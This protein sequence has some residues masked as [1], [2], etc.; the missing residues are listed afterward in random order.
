MK[1][2]ASRRGFTLIEMMIVIAIIGVL[3]G[4]LMAGISSIRRSAMRMQANEVITALY[5]AVDVYRLEHNRY[6]PAEANHQITVHYDKFYAGEASPANLLNVLRA[7]MDM[8]LNESMIGTSG[9]IRTLTDPFG[10]P[11]IYRVINPD[12]TTGGE[13]NA[14]TWWREQGVDHWVKI[15]S[16]GA[17]DNWKDTEPYWNSVGDVLFRPTGL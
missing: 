17:G 2:N 8:T 14:G 5:N 11:Y 3:M 13:G 16:V 6:P 1:T 10:H 7:S 15:Y 12:D 9:E 4:L